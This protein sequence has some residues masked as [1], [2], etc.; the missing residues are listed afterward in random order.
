MELS[1]I[2]TKFCAGDS[3]TKIVIGEKNVPKSDTT[4]CE[5]NKDEFDFVKVFN[6][7]DIHILLSS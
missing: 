4:L 5:T 3:A 7:C 6:N 2:N 1:D